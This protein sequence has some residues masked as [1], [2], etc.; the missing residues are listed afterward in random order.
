MEARR[1]LWDR[2]NG[3]EVTEG[4]VGGET[5]FHEVDDGRAGTR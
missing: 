3:D 1:Q 4:W 2:R 5:H